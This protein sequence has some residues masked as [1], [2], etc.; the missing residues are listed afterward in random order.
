MKVKVLSERG[1]EIVDRVIRDY[2]GSGL[3]GQPFWWITNDT[4]FVVS[5]FDTAFL[6]RLARYVDKDWRKHIKLIGTVSRSHFSDE[7]DSIDSSE[8]LDSLI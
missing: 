4:L 6:S 5:T 2:Y 8:Y 3:R 1:L 7:S